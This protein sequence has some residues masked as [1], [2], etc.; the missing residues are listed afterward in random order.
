MY[1]I[2]TDVG[3]SLTGGYKLEQEE[4]STFKLIWHVIIVLWINFMP[5]FNLNYCTSQNSSMSV[6]F[7]QYTKLLLV[8][9][10]YPLSTRR[11]TGQ[12]L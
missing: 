9:V 12:C 2:N 6:D 10:D 11:F 3:I 7:L 1:R 8:E 5:A 4:L